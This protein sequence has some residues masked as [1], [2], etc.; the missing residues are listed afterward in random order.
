MQPEAVFFASNSKY[1]KC[2]FLVTMV[3]I[4]VL[5][6]LVIVV[7]PYVDLPLTTLRTCVAAAL[8]VQALLLGGILKE[9]VLSSIAASMHSG[10]SLRLPSG[11]LNNFLPLLCV[12]LC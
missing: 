3:F 5:C 11:M 7:S 8:V 12:Y 10:R 2:W 4:L 1:M 9:P 6:I